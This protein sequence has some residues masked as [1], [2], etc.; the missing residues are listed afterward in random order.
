MP[1]TPAPCRVHPPRRR[2]PGFWALA[3]GVVVLHLL[4]TNHL[5]DNRVGWGSGG[6]PNRLVN[7]F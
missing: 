3:A 7:L 6:K 2:R 5:L 4:L 1:E